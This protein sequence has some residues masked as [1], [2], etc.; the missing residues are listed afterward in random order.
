MTYVL[1]A[2]SPTFPI[3]P[4]TYHQG[5]ARNGD[6]ENGGEFFGETLPLGQDLGGPLFFAHYSFIGL[7][8][9]GLSDRYANYDEQNRAH[10]LINF[11]YCVANPEG[12]EGYSEESWGL[13][14]SDGPNG[15][16]AHSPTND[17]GVIAPT[18]AISSIPYTPE[19]SLAAMRHF[20]N[21]LGDRLFGEF[22]F[23]DSFSLDANFFAESYLAIDQGPI[24]AM[25]ENHRTGLLWD[26]FMADPD[27]Q[28]GLRL[29]DFSSP[30]L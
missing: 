20:H 1:A 19:E 9:N 2:S 8:P 17:S 15:Y 25:I 23:H 30:N 26:L 12:F 4:E 3:E 5:W 11:N 7:N 18:A 29:L 28:R 10:A 16:A 6:I 13:T 22:G 27:V 14:A 21:D 24:I